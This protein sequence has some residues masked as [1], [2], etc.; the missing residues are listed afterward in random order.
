[1]MGKLKGE[2]A[3]TFWNPASTTLSYSLTSLEEEFKTTVYP[4]PLSVSLSEE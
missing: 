3:L 4:A 2:E 1:M